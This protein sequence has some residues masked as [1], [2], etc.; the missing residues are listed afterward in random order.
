MEITQFLYNFEGSFDF[1]GILHRI[2]DLRS[3]VSI[4]HS[5][6]DENPV[7]FIITFQGLICKMYRGSYVMELDGDVVFGLKLIEKI[8]INLEFNSNLYLNTH[9]TIIASPEYEIKP[10][11]IARKLASH[12][13]KINQ[14]D[15]VMELMNG[16]QQVMDKVR[17]LSILEP[18]DSK[19]F[20]KLE[21]FIN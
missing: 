20:I 12:I 11:F 9:G 1:N 3:F 17:I 8:F 19:A 6:L 21:T 4:S 15:F 18:V 2:I 13:D 5:E 16:N 7:E 14:Y 10:P